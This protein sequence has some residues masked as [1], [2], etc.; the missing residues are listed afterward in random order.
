MREPVRIA[1]SLMVGLFIILGLSQACRK[2]GSPLPDD[3][4]I[5]TWDDTAMTVAQ[6]KKFMNIRFTHEARAS[7]KPLSDR[8]NILNEYILRDCK[9]L[10][11]KRLGFDKRPDIQKEYQNALEQKARELLYNMEV[12][13]RFFTRSMLEDWVEHDREE[14]RCRHIL[15][16]MPE[17]VK[18]KDTLPYWNRIKEIWEKAKAG[19]DFVSL[20]DKYSEDKTIA[21]ERHGDL[22]F[23][24]WGKMVD[25]FQ[26]AAWKLKPGEI[27]P[28]VR[29]R[30][31]YHI[32]QLLDRRPRDIDFHTSHILVKVSRRDS[33]AETL[34]AW[35]RAKKIWEEARKPGAD[36]RALARAYSED[37]DTWVDGEVG[38]V[39]RGS[40]PSEYWEECYKMKEGEVS[41]PVRTYKG[42]HIIKLNQIRKTKQDLDD[43]EFRESVLGKIAYVY[44]NELQAFANQYMDS[45][46]KAYGM[47]YDQAVLSLVLR[48][49]NDK[50]IPQN[51]SPF[52]GFT[53]EERQ[54]VLI[55]DKLGGVTVQDLVDRYGDHR[56]PLQP[57]NDPQFVTNLA[58]PIATD[59]YLA[60]IARAKG[61]YNDPRALEE[62]QRAL[63]NA[64][65]PEVEREMVFSKAAPSEEEMIEYYQ[66]NKEKYTDPAKATIIEVL[67]DD[68]QLAQDIASRAKKGEDIATLAR[69]YT[70]RE[71]AKNVGGRL[72]PFKRDEYGEVSR[73]AF[74]AKVGD[75]VGPIKADEKFYS[76]FKVVEKTEERLKP[77]D[78]VR[79][80]I[81]SD[82][83]FQQQKNIKEAWEKELRRAYKI[84]IDE[85][86]AARVWPLAE[87]LPD[88]EVEARKQW[89]KERAEMAKV[90][91]QENKIRLKLKPGTQEITT[92][93]GKKIQ[94]KIGE[95]RYIDK[96]GK[97]SDANRPKLRVTPQPASPQKPPAKTSPKKEEKTR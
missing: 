72:G 20:V 64:I 32:I 80:Q 28:I 76:V 60:D 68:A 67:V 45:V 7:K 82:L 88:K 33:P 49:L 94:V 34:L 77:F 85:D 63:S 2:G 83:R 44:R 27:S 86:L 23:F 87:Q 30:Y 97:K 61:L 31:G 74:E 92:K 39:S 35:E 4:I 70:K 62:A 16:S 48:K 90:K 29:T 54:M 79:P 46:R 18:G 78:E 21:P 12:R 22:G 17:E 50:N 10:E 6:F 41:R 5:A 95:P 42:Y 38:W 59:R 93:E 1:S 91:E 26:E 81:E 13:D 89:R 73:R 9:I 3:A 65:L 14:V 43:P 36:F 47:E 58:T 56:I 71:K 25:E 15:I 8:L 55:K 66:K 51:M 69:R 19:E 52:S 75:L 84:R 96:E 40:M 53:P 11:G 24:N 37:E 57:T